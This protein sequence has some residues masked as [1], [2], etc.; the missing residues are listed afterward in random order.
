MLLYH[1]GQGLYYYSPPPHPHL[2]GSFTRRESM[3][4]L[5]WFTP[6]FSTFL[7]AK[8]A[9][10]VL[11]PRAFNWILLNSGLNAI[12]A[13]TH[14]FAGW[15][16]MY[17][18]WGWVKNP[19]DAGLDTYGSFGYPNHAATYF[20]LLFSFAAGLF[21]REVLQD[22][23]RIRP[24][25][26]FFLGA[27]SLLFFFTA[28]FSASRAGIL[29][30]WFVLSFLIMTLS[31]L[32]WPRLHPV[33]RL[34][35][36]MGVIFLLFILIACF[37]MLADPIHLRELSRA[38]TDLDL[39]REIGARF[40]QIQSAWD[41]W[42]DHPWFGVGGWGYRY[43]VSF[44]LD[45]SMWGVL[46]RGKANVHNDFFQ[47]LCEFGIV[48]MSF[49]T[50]VFVPA[51]F[52]V[53][54]DIRRPADHDQSFWADPLRFSLGFGLLLMTA[55]SM[56]DLPFRSPAVFAHGALFLVLASQRDGTLSIWAP[57]VHWHALRPAVR[58][59]APTSNLLTDT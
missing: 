1:F 28:Q 46:G 21:L 58:L 51:V 10:P 55:H 26:L 9:F 31:I 25:R 36:T 52:R 35:G 30:V 27:V 57:V 15:R 47:F 40:F 3:E 50:M 6:V 4:M 44:Y 56:I 38:T 32:G 2:P 37:R 34:Y 42:K 19:R 41:I 13:L 49:L 12:L 24:L 14:E 20:I 8:H 45:P 59:R 54:R 48:G 17:E 23:S 43:L 5:R 39:G 29:G 33:Q 7:I 22:R 16:Y 18:F 11:M 53:L